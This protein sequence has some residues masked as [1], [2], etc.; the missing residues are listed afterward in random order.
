[1]AKR[2]KS[3]KLLYILGGIV[4]LLV[5]TA[6]V[7]RQ[8]GWIGKPKPVEVEL[9]KAK[10][11]EIIEK[12]SASGKIQPEVEVK[13]SP[14]VSGEITELHVAEGDSVVQGQLLLKIRPDNY[15]S[16]V[17]RAL[18]TVNNNRANLAQAQARLAQ[19]RAQLAR[20][21]VEFA[22]NK[23]LYEEKVISDSDF[24]Q[25]QTDFKV[26]QEEVLSAEQNVQASKYLISSAEAGLQD[27][28][29][30]LR[31]TTILAPVSGTI[32]KLDVEKG[33]RV[34]GTSQMAGTEMLR[35]AN[36]NNME[37]LVDVNENDI[38]R[39]NL[40]D[41][42]VIEVDSYANT[43]KKFKGIVTLVSNTAKA[44]ASQDAVT[45]FE[46]K[47]RILNESFADLVRDNKKLPPFRPGMTASVDIITERKSSVLS[48]PLASVTTRNPNVPVQG[49]ENPEG[50]PENTNPP[51]RQVANKADEIKEVVFV[52]NNGKAEMREVK[53][54]IS[55]FE[56]IEIL[57]GLKE[58]DEVVSGPFIVISKRL[59]N[60]D[61]VA[62]KQAGKGDKKDKATQGGPQS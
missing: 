8:A 34:V 48:V 3:N 7:A 36:L 57:S 42:A 47:V 50:G 31:K 35:I 23:K 58:G 43:D 51:A 61:D 30:N 25:A 18:A 5:I 24:L 2:K 6:V 17:D 32:S 10:R 60:G 29:E 45:E 62:K 28:R 26:A 41:T 20:S 38:V 16:A 56:N 55:D 33:E 11:T 39:V 37:V 9:A 53:T 22:R 12:V 54:G 59:N 52:H 15:L 14:D 44:A 21:E 46:V 49:T 19:S 27:A 40:G 4:L 13:I 1:M